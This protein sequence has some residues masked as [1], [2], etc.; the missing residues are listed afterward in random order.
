MR[1]FMLVTLLFPGLAAAGDF[2]DDLWFTRNQIMD[3]AGYC[4]GSTL[5]Q[6]MFDNRDCIG[7]SVTLTP[8]QTHLVNAIRKSE[9]DFGCKVNTGQRRLDLDDKFI[10]E[11]LIDLPLRDEFESACLGYLGTPVPLFAGR[12]PATPQTGII[13]PG[14]YVSFSH[15]GFGNW[16]YVTARYSDFS[17]KSGGWTNTGFAEKSCQQ[18]AG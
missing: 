12:N 10:R 15:Y 1:I 4:F 7:K 3:R 9:Q 14:D 17:I 13:V 16:A 5:G 11:E 18:W 6:T 2:C 8:D